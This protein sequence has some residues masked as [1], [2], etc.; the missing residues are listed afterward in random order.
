M[1]RLTRSQA[2]PIGLDIGF[3]SIKMLQLESAGP[4]QT[5]TLSVVA[6]ARQPLPE[7]ARQQPQLRM[8]LAVDV[9]RR[10]LREGGFHGRRI[11][12]SL[13]REFIHIKNLRLPLIPAHELA[14]AVQYEAKNIFPFDCEQAHVRHMLAGEVRQGPDVR[15]EVIVMAARHEDVDNY[16]EQLHHANCIVDSL[17][18][19]PLA[20]Y[21]SLDR[22][23]RRREDEQEVHVFVD[24]GARRSQ[25]IIGKGREISFL[26]SIEIGS[27]QLIDAISQRLS[28]SPDE[29]R[30]VRRKL[31]DAGA[32]TDPTARR[33]PVSQAVFDATRSIIEDLS[34]EVSL[35]LRYYSVTFRGHR[36]VKVRLAG[37]EATNT[38]LQGIL[39]SALTLPVE[40]ARPLI[41]VDTSRMKST[42]R[43]GPMSEWTLA[44][45]LALRMTRGTFAPRDGKPR[46]NSPTGTS[47]NVE[48]VDINE[49]IQNAEGGETVAP[50]PGTAPAMSSTNTLARELANA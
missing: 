28:I 15:Q 20:L 31:A 23:I 44:L 49:A 43:R 9:I 50:K 25:V 26:K 2:Q 4:M 46:E 34:R 38:Q 36:P 5:Q 45:G 33:D 48:V 6:A 7:E 27:N 39:T 22:F 32:A 21:R 12:A 41:S 40:A 37:G 18:V 11:V 35:C 8:A 3:D 16:L 10:M 24:I 17:D 30:A 19:E 14:P 1:I 42:D 29:A 47:R 13:P